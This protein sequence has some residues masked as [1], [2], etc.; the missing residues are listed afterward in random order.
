MASYKLMDTNVIVRD[1]GAFIPQDPRNRDFR[2]YEAWLAK[3]NTPAPPDAEPMVTDADFVEQEIKAS[4]TLQTL[5]AVIAK[6]NGVTE[7]E[8]MNTIR[9]EAKPRGLGGRR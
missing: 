6:G 5:V 8:M 4:S 2:R 3:G 1:D 9:A 7:A